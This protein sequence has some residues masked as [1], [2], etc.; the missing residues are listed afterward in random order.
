MAPHFPS[1]DPSGLQQLF[2]PLPGASSGWGGQSFGAHWRTLMAWSLF[3]LLLTWSIVA[4]TAGREVT[5]AAGA[6]AHWLQLIPDGY[7]A[8]QQNAALWGYPLC[9]CAVP[10]ELV[11]L[12]WISLSPERYLPASLRPSS[13]WVWTALVV[14]SCIAAGPVL[15]LGYQLSA[16]GPISFS[17][18]ALLVG[19]LL[20]LLA[21]LAVGLVL[22]V[23]YV[24]DT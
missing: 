11:T 16:H 4:G 6:V 5:A 7:P 18:L 21:I 1:E 10:A 14:A 12:L 9:V 19:P 17:F 13:T 8:P 3:G 15:L 20:T 23:V 2:N 24:L 22:L